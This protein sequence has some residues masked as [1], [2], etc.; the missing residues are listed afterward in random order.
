M[1]AIPL[2][3]AV[4]RSIAAVRRRRDDVETFVVIPTLM[5]YSIVRPAEHSDYHS[6]FTTRPIRVAQ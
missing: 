2:N 3:G 5:P 1:D 6:P 4:M